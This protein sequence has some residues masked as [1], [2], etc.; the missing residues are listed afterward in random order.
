MAVSSNR[1]FRATLAESGAPPLTPVKVALHYTAALSG[2][3]GTMDGAAVESRYRQAC[4]LEDAGRMEEAAAAYRAVVE[5]DP[6]HAKARNNLGSALQ[7]L[8]RMEEALACFE[9]AARLDPL[10]WQPHYN[11]GMHHKLAGDPASAVRPFQEAMRRKRGPAAPAIA[12]DPTFQ[13]VSKAKLRHDIEQFDYLLGLG[14]LDAG[15]RDV[16]A[17]LRAALAALPADLAAGALV[18][19]PGGLSGAVARAYNRLVHFHDAPEVPGSALNLSLD[20]AAIEAAYARLWPG[21]V[22]LDGLLAPAALAGLRRFCLE[23]TVWF[24]FPYADGYLGAYFEDGFACPLLAQIARE[25]PQALPGI[26][27]GER[28]TELWAYKYDSELDGIDV[29][30]DFAAVNVNFWITPDAAN[31]AP[32]SGGL[33]LWDRQAPIDWDFGAYNKDVPRMR[34]FLQRTGARAIT[35]PHRQ[36]RAVIFHSDL[37]H[38]TDA[39]RFRPGYENRRINITML[40]GERGAGS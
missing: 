1:E 5:A 7:L 13:K 16:V 32:E 9:A 30:G 29:H 40:Y 22:H 21:R 24:D 35:V 8:G 14:V 39:I 3:E 15:Y 26:F 37:F 4:E 6:R 33:V 31:L 17:A 36:N 12:S 27:R 10:L 28:L 18:D 23:S 25:L 19:F 34:A 11:I 20:S 2:M 38:E